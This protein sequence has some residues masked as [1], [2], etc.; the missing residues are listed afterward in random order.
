MTLSKRQNMR[1]MKGEWE[2]C[3]KINQTPPLEVYETH[4]NYFGENIRIDVLDDIIKRKEKR[5]D[6]LKEAK[7]IWDKEFKK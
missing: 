6:I 4:I 1:E 3:W 7:E 2:K 5:L